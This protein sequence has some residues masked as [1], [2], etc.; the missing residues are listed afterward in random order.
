M[1]Y[2]NM[3]TEWFD[4]PQGAS[5]TL[6]EKEGMPTRQIS[7]LH[8]ENKRRRFVPSLAPHL[9]TRWVPHSHKEFR[10]RDYEHFK[11]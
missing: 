3:S 8:K 1:M 9:S 4:V 6:S 2:L 10:F 7:H 11:T 5:T